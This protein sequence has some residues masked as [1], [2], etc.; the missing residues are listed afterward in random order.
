MSDS[1]YT[2]EVPST[3]IWVKVRDLTDVIR[4]ASPRPKGDPRYFGGSVP[5]IMI[6]DVSREPGKYLSR[7]KEGVTPEGA[8]RSRLLQPGALILSNSGTVCVPKILQ[9]EGCIHDGFVSF[10]SLPPEVSKDYLY[11]WFASIRDKVIQQ[12]KQGITQVNLNTEIVRDL[13]IPLAPAGEQRRIVAKIEE[14]FSDLDAAVAALERVQ[15]K[16]KRYRAAVLKAAVEGKLTAEWR[17]QHPNTEPAAELLARILDERRRRWEE[18]QLARY[19]QARKEPPNN[20]REKY[21]APMPPDETDLPTIPT[22]WVVASLDQLSLTITSGSRDW[23]QYY[24]RGSGTFIMAQNVRPGRLDLS[25]RQLVDPP[26]GDRDRA[27][28][29]VQNGDLLITI[30][31][32]NTGDVCRVRGEIPEHY[33]CQSVALVRPVDVRCSAFL[34]QYFV[35]DENGQ[36]QFRRY[37]YGQGRPHLGFDELRVTAVVLPP[38]AEQAEIVREI[39]DRLSVVDQL[40]AQVEATLKRSS[41]L[42]QGILKRAFEGRLVPQDSTDEPAEKLLERIQAER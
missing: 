3:W 40:T 21:Q 22:T 11:Y 8:S 7:T 25:S 24:N 31:G 2:F 28:S 29:Q 20:W 16:L 34:E 37:I 39:E 33:V 17:A 18:A 10:P 38:L 15:A 41:R 4:G 42:R 14:L 27:R 19:A 26:P 13:D 36:R 5:W 1:P 35:S 6:S 9:I 12:N 32:A 30:V 23:S